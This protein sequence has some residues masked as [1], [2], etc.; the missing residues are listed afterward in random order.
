MLRREERLAGVDPRLQAV[1]RRAAATYPHDII[2]LEGVRSLERQQQLVKQGASKTLDSKHLRGKAVDVAPVLDTDGD[3][4]VEA[5]WHWPHYDQ[6]A[7]HMKAAALE[8]GVNLQWGGD[9]RT[10]KDGPHWELRH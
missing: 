4:D 2:V 7:P 5:S 10:F 1:V 3:G 6:L 8:L 9:W